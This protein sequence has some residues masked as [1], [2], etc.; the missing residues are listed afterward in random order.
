MHPPKTAKQVCGFPGLVGYYRKFIEDFA[1]IA[2]PITLLTCHKAKF[3]WIPTH[4]TA[5]MMLKE[6]ILQAPFVHYPDQAKK[7][8]VYTD[9]SDNTCG[10]QLSQGRDPNLPPH[11]LLK[12]MHIS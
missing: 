12:P 7:Y 2:K 8:I 5:I 6:A 3:V 4:H 10:A 9:A 11:Q 1:K